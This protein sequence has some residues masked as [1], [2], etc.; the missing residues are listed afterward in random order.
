MVH[1]LMPKPSKSWA[2]TLFQSL[3]GSKDCQEVTYVIERCCELLT[4]GDT[5][6][7]EKF[8]SAMYE[9]AQK[10]AADAAATQNDVT[11]KVSVANDVEV[12][13]TVSNDVAEKMIAANDVAQNATATNN[14]V[15]KETV[16]AEMAPANDTPKS[17]IIAK[18][19]A[20]NERPK[21]EVPLERL[22]VHQGQRI[23]R[24]VTSMTLTARVRPTRHVRKAPGRR[25]AKPSAS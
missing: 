14:A 13:V 18:N 4:S 11:D 7:D 2:Q 15:V 25:A 5:P 6:S 19:T 22:R 3:R 1:L 8:A 17:V 12:T 9:A 20:F 16:A 21:P 24:Q 10:I 23:Q